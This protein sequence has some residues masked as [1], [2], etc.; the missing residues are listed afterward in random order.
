MNFLKH[1]NSDTLI[2]INDIR[3][4]DKGN[5]LTIKIYMRSTAGSSN[6]TIQY[7]FEFNSFEERDRYF[8]RLQNLL[9]IQ[10]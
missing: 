6:S 2:N 1:H 8:N 9:V 4:I 5:Q 3:S 10:L 7:S